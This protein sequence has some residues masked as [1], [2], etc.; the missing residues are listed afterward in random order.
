MERKVLSLVILFLGAICA[1]YPQSKYGS[2]TMEELQME[3]YSQDTSAVALILLKDGETRFTYNEHT[4]FKFEYTQEMKIKILKKEGLDWCDQQ[5]E[6]YE[7]DR[8]S[9]EVV[10]GLSGTTYNLENGKIV[11]TKLSKEFI[12]D[13]DVNENWKVKKFTMP[14]AKIGSVVEFK[15]TIESNFF[16]ELRDFEFQAS[17]PSLYSRYQVV[18]PEFYDYNVDVSGYIRITAKDE[19]VND[20]FH[21]TYRDG[22]GHIR[23]EMYTYTSKKRTFVAENVPAM[24]DEKYMWCKDDYISRI[25]F[26]LRSTQFPYQTIKTYTSSWGKIDEQLLKGNFGGNLKKTGLF[27]NDIAKQE[28]T[29]DN[30]SAILE[31]IK[32][33]VKW[34][35]KNTYYPS[36]LNNVLKDGIG[37]SADMNFLLINALNAAGFEAYPVVMSTR[38]NGRMPIIHPSISALNYVITGVTIDSKEYYTDASA[39]YG[40]WNLLPEKCMVTQARSLKD[41][42]GSWVNL[43]TLS[44]ATT[45]IIA[46]SKLSDNLYQS[47]ITWTRKGN[48]GLSFRSKYFSN[49]K[50]KDDY[51]SKLAANMNG[52]I[53]DFELMN[54]DDISKEIRTKFK[55]SNDASLGDE[56]IYIN[57]LVVK[58]FNDNPF[59]D[60]ERI[61]PV[62]FNYLVNFIQIVE[63]EIPE[64]YEVEE[65]PKS[66]KFI[67]DENSPIVFLYNIT[68]SENQIRLQYQFQ[69]KKLLFVQEE[70]PVLKD[71]FAK[72]ILKNSEQIV[73]KKKANS[74]VALVIE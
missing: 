54:E 65:L 41:R 39:K 56:H 47:D 72:V 53:S 20:G 67:I 45:L 58:L 70:Y 13:G 63:F 1:I 32:D 68:Q 55:L 23:S 37:N 48:E 18:I 49:Y 21:Y 36:N 42:A 34:N 52:E 51:I 35:E 19:N 16:W 57:P 50:D 4:G 38:G 44:S 24:K 6:Y 2:A 31:M 29:L 10:K 15:Y 40:N 3:S 11:K 12:F 27:K 14:A 26:E 64:G 61:F 22:N 30:A 5:I 28:T 17:I 25:S 66:E 60:E 59:V 33:K 73:L 74:E 71:F 43:S 9:K 46:K 7:A 69:L 8:T 62:N